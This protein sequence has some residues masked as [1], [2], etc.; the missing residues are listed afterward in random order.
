M[1][2]MLSERM[3]QKLLLG[4]RQQLSH[5]DPQALSFRLFS[6]FLSEVENILSHSYKAL[7]PTTLTQMLNAEYYSTDLNKMVPHQL[8]RI[9]IDQKLNESHLL[10]STIYRP[11]SLSYTTMNYKWKEP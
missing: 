8:G 10:I 3:K 1:K 7:E 6:A 11:I 9:G 2:Q 5:F 4:F